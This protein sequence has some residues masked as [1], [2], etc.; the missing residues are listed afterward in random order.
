MTQRYTVKDVRAA[1]EY[2]GRVSTS[3]NIVL[4][5]DELILQ[6]GSAQNGQPYRLFLRENGRT[7]MSNTPFGLSGGYLGSTAREAA[8]SLRMLASGVDA[9][10]SV[11]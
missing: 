5:N 8:Q 7:G 9:A 2:L 11:R 6:E 1:F 3:A 4:G 10:N